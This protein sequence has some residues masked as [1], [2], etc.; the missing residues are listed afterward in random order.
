[1]IRFRL[2]IILS[3]VKIIVLQVALVTELVFF[4]LK[5]RP[6]LSGNDI[7]RYNCLYNMLVRINDTLFRIMSK[8]FKK[9][10]H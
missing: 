10:T 2:L 7:L 4:L 1:M 9:K 8:I 6:V 3:C 5:C